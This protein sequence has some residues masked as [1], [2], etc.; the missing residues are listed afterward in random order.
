MDIYCLKMCYC[1][2]IY[3]A[4]TMANDLREIN[5]PRKEILL[6]VLQLSYAIDPQ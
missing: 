2:L 3:N 1:R 5:P 6:F 4:N